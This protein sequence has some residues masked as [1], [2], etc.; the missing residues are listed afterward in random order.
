MT[1]TIRV[2]HLVGGGTVEMTTANWH[3]YQK[4]PLAAQYEVVD[5]SGCLTCNEPA[6]PEPEIP[7]E[8][9]AEQPRGRKA[10]PNSD[11]EET[12]NV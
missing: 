8:Q 1:D 10:R 12:E 2:R 4:T 11:S 6:A 5:T 9:V 7:A 3:A